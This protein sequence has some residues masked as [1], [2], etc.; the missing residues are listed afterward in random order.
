MIT[1]LNDDFLLRSD[2]YAES[3]ANI[4][5]PF[6][7]S[8]RKPFSIT[9]KDQNPINGFVFYSDRPR[10]TVLILHGFTENTTKYSELIYSLLNNCFSVVIYDQR[11]HGTSWRD[12]ELKNLSVTHVDHFSEYVS[13]LCTVCQE[14]LPKMPRPWSLFS[15]S[16]GGAVASLF[17][18]QNHGIFSNAVF[19]APMIAPDSNGFPVLAAKVLCTIA[20]WIGHGKRHP[21]FLKTYQGPEDFETSC[22]TDLNRFLWY[23]KIK[24]ATPE[25]Q[26]CVPSYSWI[27]ESILVKDQIL[28]PGA[29]ESISCPVLLFTAE[30]DRNV[31]PDAQQQFIHRIPDA[32]YCLV[33]DARHEIY[34]SSDRVLYPWW[35]QVLAFLKGE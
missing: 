12:P 4:A 17:L 19:C 26:N 23:D 20:G 11:G 24:S 21:F 33:K 28:A 5:T 14:I 30:H 16:M 1:E 10:G 35:H 18:E 13:D 2:S 8:C 7:L 25:Y 9:G 34:R 22:A 6:L 29:P 32:S 3:M 31:L 15:H 27:R